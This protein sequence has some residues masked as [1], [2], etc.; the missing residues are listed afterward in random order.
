MANIRPLSTTCSSQ[1]DSTTVPCP[2]DYSSSTNT[3]HHHA[4]RL[5]STWQKEQ[6]IQP[7]PMVRF[8]FISQCH[9]N[10][11]NSS[12]LFQIIA[13]R[14]SQNTKASHTAYLSQSRNPAQIPLQ[15][16]LTALHSAMMTAQSCSVRVVTVH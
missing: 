3:I 12:S 9:L 8:T 2:R 15:Q 11:G 5:R 16:P 4:L 13:P 10:T 6:C 1:K 7:G 14:V